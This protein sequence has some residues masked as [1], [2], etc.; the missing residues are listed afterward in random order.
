MITVQIDESTATQLAMFCKR[1]TIE[2]VGPFS[3]DEGEAYEMM[4]AL[5][6]LRLILQEQGYF[7]R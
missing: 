1:A 7:F 4:K 6:D 2:R 3:A 5:E